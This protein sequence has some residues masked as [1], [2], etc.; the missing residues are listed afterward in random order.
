[1]EVKNNVLLQLLR[2]Y[3]FYAKLDLMWLLRD[4]KYAILAIITDTVS[5]LA[6]VSSVFLLAMRFN[7]V[8]GR[9]L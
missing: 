5:S 4:A 9:G 7:G 2:L 8:S 6:A 3:G 1:M